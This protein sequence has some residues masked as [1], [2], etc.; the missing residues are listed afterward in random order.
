M[1]VCRTLRRPDRR[2]LCQQMD[3]CIIHWWGTSMLFLFLSLHCSQTSWLDGR[4]SGNQ[5]SSFTYAALIWPEPP[6][7]VVSVYSF[8][9]FCTSAYKSLLTK[10]LT[11]MLM[12]CSSVIRDSYVSIWAFFCIWVKCQCLLCL[13]RT[14]LVSYLVSEAEPLYVMLF[15]SGRKD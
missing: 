5:L 11:L 8:Y 9:I 3:S 1:R 10:L 14:Y 12:S 7:D 13:I 4:N 2:V 15:V 6:R